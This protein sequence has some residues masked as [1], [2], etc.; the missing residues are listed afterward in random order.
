MKYDGNNLMFVPDSWVENI[1]QAYHNSEI[2]YLS[3][4]VWTTELRRLPG[5]T[6]IEINTTIGMIVFAIF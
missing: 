2:L 1:I 6:E 3:Q 5:D 4:R